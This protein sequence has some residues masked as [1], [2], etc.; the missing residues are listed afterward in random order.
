[1]VE[2]IRHCRHGNFDVEVQGPCPADAPCHCQKRMEPLK[3]CPDCGA[4]PGKPHYDGCD[5]E[6]CTVCGNQRLS[7]GCI[8]HDRK[9]ARWTGIWPGA[10]ESSYLGINLNEFYET[11][12]HK[13]F[14]VK[15]RKRW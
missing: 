12:Y 11:G 7:C 14:F 1:M 8:G 2:R 9:F 10:A 3:N 15:Q 5:V 13:I 6:R 4:V